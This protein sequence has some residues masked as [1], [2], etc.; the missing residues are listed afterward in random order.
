MR[1]V[2]LVVGTCLFI[3]VGWTF[4]QNL[5]SRSVIPVSKAAKVIS[6]APKQRIE[7][8]L[9]RW[10]RDLETAQEQSVKNGKPILV[11]FQEVPGCAGCQ[12]FG[13]EV[14][15]QPLIVDAVQNEFVP[16]LVYN[17]RSSGQDAELLKRFRE[18]AWN[19]QVLR[20]LD[21]NAKDIIPRRDQVWTVNAV[22]RRL[23]DAL[24]AVDRPVPKYLQSLVSSS[25]PKNQQLAAFAMNCFWIGE[26]ELGRIEGVTATEAGWLDGREVTLVR[27][28]P[29]KV[30]L[31]SLA[32]QAAHVRC[33]QKMY[34][35]NGKRVGRLPVG[36]L[37]KSYRTESASDQKRQLSRI[38]IAGSV[39]SINATQLTKLNAL[40]PRNR[41]TALEW[42]SPSQRSWLAR[43]SK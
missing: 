22:S 15:S 16:V 33:A 30:S 37:D 28:E 43:H 29:S 21:S 13:R 40:L 39:P 4:A 27:Y 26:Y 9:V 7:V 19:Y 8:G 24:E 2:I 14:L 25:S 6:P 10:G 36:K 32:T 1:T 42:L 5:E 18:P 12:K 34:T 38:P 41:T 23:V 20:F 31:K 17:N 35:P 3:G 11:L